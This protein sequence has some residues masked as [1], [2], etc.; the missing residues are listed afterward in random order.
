MSFPALPTAPLVTRLASL[1]A[2]LAGWLLVDGLNR[3]LW[4]ALG[5]GA[6]DLALDWFFRMDRSQR[7]VMLVLIAGSLG[8]FL[9]RRLIRPLSLSS[10]DDALALQ[11]E[12]GNRG[13]GEG[14][15][16]ALQLARISDVQSRGMSPVLVRAAILSGAQAA[17]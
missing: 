2:R 6:A 3:V 5:L 11:V 15:I 13:L 17:E 14:L 7:L 10:S 16:S 12:A 9:Y 4:L 1:R 8:W